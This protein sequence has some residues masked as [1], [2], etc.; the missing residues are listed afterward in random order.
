MSNKIL[1]LC[2]NIATMYKN[3][4]IK[5]KL[6]QAKQIKTKYYFTLTNYLVMIY[7]ISIEKKFN[8][9]SILKMNKSS[10]Y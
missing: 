8:I 2:K 3:R 5:D 6:Y 7:Q 4:I 1:I 9:V 10:T